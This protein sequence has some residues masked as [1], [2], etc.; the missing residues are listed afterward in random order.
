MTSP[1]CNR[2]LSKY[3]CLLSKKSNSKPSPFDEQN[4]L[5]IVNLPRN[6]IV[7]VR[8]NNLAGGMPHIGKLLR[9]FTRRHEVNARLA[10]AIRK[11]E[12]EE[13]ITFTDFFN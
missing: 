12:S 5:S 6:L 8:L 7:D 13:K 1:V 2:Q 11:N 10:E 4:L 9:E 3:S